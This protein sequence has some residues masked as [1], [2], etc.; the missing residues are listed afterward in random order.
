M[1]VTLLPLIEFA[2]GKGVDSLPISNSVEPSNENFSISS[3]DALSQAPHLWQANSLLQ[4]NGIQQTAYSTCVLDE[5]V[6][7]EAMDN[8]DST[9]VPVHDATDSS[10]VLLEGTQARNYFLGNSEHETPCLNLMEWSSQ[11]TNLKNYPDKNEAKKMWN[12]LQ[13]KDISDEEF[14]NLLINSIPALNSDHSMTNDE[15][16]NTHVSEIQNMHGHRTEWCSENT[17]LENHPDGNEAMKKWNML[18]TMDISDEEINNLII[19]SIPALNS[20]HSMA[21][22]EDLHT[23]VPEMQNMHGQRTECQDHLTKEL[24][25]KLEADTS[26]INFYPFTPVKVNLSKE[27]YSSQGMMRTDFE[28]AVSKSNGFQ[29]VKEYN[30]TNNPLSS[31]EQIFAH[32]DRLNRI[33]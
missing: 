16:L 18:Q 11:N 19:N 30:F 32:V 15:D 24:R 13:A 22:D 7:S 14:N 6:I 9:E 4:N 26:D 27:I 5:F 8:S 29:T 17:K 1:N 25:N 10:E 33:Y 28:E 3:D 12:I 31:S 21:N 20:N 2:N 23:L